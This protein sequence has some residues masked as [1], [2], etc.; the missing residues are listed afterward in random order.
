MAGRF[1]FSM[2]ERR[3]A[4]DPWFRI[5]TLDITTTMLV[6]IACVASL[7]VWAISQ[8]VHQYLWLIPDDVKHGELWRLLTWPIANV[9]D[10][11]TVITIAIFWYFGKQVEGMLGRNKFAIMLLLLA[12]IPGIVGVL[13]DTPQAGLAPIELAV[14]LVFVAEYPFVRFFFN[15]PAWAI[16]A[17]VVGIQVLQYL[18]NRDRNSIILL[19]VT[20]AVAALTARSMGLAQSLP[21]IPKIPYPSRSRRQRRRTGRRG[22]GDVISGP[23]G[24]STRTEPYRGSLPQP[25]RPAEDPRDQAELDDLLDKISAAGME[26]LSAEEKRRLNELSKRL[27]NRR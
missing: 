15:I 6:V 26:G 11:W 21:W 9:P 4:S 19:F 20:I 7:F 17:V 8:D 10:L 5:G 23:W 1:S 18:G 16:G 3:D 27:R 13:L 22:N 14:F 25:P 2:P 24:S 12:V